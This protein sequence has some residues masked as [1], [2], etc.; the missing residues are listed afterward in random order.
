MSSIEGRPVNRH[1]S[2][3]REESD[4]EMKQQDNLAFSVETC[5]VSSLSSS[6]ENP[7]FAE[8]IVVL[9]FHL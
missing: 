2:I 1:G 9:K 5:M 4:D 6:S 3:I 7:F 8:N